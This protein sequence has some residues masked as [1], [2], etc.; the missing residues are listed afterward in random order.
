MRNICGC[1]HFY[2]LEV[3]CQ[4][5]Q[6]FGK[7]L[8]A[9]DSSF[10]TPISWCFLVIVNVLDSMKSMNPAKAVSRWSSCWNSMI[11]QGLPKERSSQSCKGFSSHL[12]STVAF[13][14]WSTDKFYRVFRRACPMRR[15]QACH[16]V[17]P[18]SRRDQ[19][20]ERTLVRPN[21]SALSHWP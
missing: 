13:D 8:A 6:P 15:R 11:V 7:T 18:P 3:L 21:L 2:D 20:R 17:F 12:W 4:V 9:V 1:W 16:R 10:H 14:H 19:G 5:L